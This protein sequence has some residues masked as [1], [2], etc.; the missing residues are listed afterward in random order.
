[1]PPNLKV[2]LQRSSIISHNLIMSSSVMNYLST[3]VIEYTTIKLSHVLIN[4]HFLPNLL[5]ESNCTRSLQQKNEMHS[6]HTF[7]WAATINQLCK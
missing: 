2:V 6:S 4:G 1:M 7:N 5:Q 3:R